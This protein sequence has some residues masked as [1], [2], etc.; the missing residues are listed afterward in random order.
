MN[1]LTI[2]AIINPH[3]G[4]QNIG[5]I[6]SLLKQYIN[7]EIFDLK[8]YYTE[9]KGHASKIAAE[10]VK[11]KIDI[12]AIVG[13]DGSVNEVASQLVHTDTALAVIPIGSGNGF[14]RDLK[15]PLD[16]KSAIERIQLQNLK[17]IDV[18]KINDLYFFSTTGLGY[19]AKVA[20]D[21]DRRTKRGFWGYFKDIIH[22]YFAYF[23]ENY[24]INSDTAQVSGNFF[25]VT[26]ANSSQW[27]YNVQVAPKASMTDGLMNIC[28]C[29]RPPLYAVL[30]FGIKMLTHRIHYSKYT[31][32]LLTSKV[33]VQ[34]LNISEIVAH[35]D[36]EPIKMSSQMTV[37]I[38]PKALK[39]LA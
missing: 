16:V 13:G 25:F 23:P 14:A 4:H 11:E 18:G 29:N 5:E 2:R 32:T 27:G 12:V 38:I 8:I 19:D 7:S 26:F 30:K 39:I 37:E 34:V 17:I 35:I 33:H 31:H 15:I 28:C 6:T 9:Y 20:F 10:A 24:V 1:K 22:N 3:S 36:G 21:Y